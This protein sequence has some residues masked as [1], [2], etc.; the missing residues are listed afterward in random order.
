LR[1]IADGRLQRSQRWHAAEAG[2]SERTF[3]QVVAEAAEVGA[4]LVVEHRS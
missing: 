1:E 4:I 2:C 3:R